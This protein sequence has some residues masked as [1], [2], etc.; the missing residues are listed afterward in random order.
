MVEASNKADLL[1]A[2]EK[3]QYEA[4]M[5]LGVSPSLAWQHANTRKSYWRTAH[6]WIL[7]TTFTNG[8]LHRKGWVFLGDVYK[9]RTQGSY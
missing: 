4:L 2:V 1:E 6:S 7:A 9:K 8:F 3:D 5:R